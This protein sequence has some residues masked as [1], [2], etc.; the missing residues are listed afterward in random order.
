MG[1]VLNLGQLI[2]ERATN[3]ELEN[4][5][6]EITWVIITDKVNAHHQDGGET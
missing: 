6:I 5:E 1:V 3:R 4:R 2:Y